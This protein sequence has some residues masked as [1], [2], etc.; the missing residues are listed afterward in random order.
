MSNVVTIRGENLYSK[1]ELVE[2]QKNSED[3]SVLIVLDYESPCGYTIARSRELTRMEMLWLAEIL[4]R[5]AFE[6]D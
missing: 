4:R 1:E 2:H 3:A 5:A 6:D